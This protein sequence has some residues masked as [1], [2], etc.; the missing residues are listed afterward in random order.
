MGKVKEPAA[1]YYSRPMLNALRNHIKD[2]IE[3]MDD[4]VLLSKLSSMLDKDEESFE[5]RYQRAKEFAYTHLD[6]EFAEEL[7]KENFLIGKP[8]PCQY[9]DE[10]FEKE[11]KQSE[12]SGIATDEEV[13]AAF[14]LWLNLKYSGQI[15]HLSYFKRLYIGMLQIWEYNSLS[16]LQRM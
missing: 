3:Q 16:P 2:R 9:T 6:R 15:G 13:K 8:I 4:A 10:E 12:A 11:S 14:T 7:E 1:T 5:E